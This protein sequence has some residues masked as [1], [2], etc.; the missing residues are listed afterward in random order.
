LT[1]LSDLFNTP[2]EIEFEGKA[3]KLRKPTQFEESRF[4][5]WL[6][7][8]ARADAA[9]A[10]GPDGFAERYMAVVNK[11]IAC[12]TYAWGGAAAVE[13][14]LT[15]A[16][17]TKMLQI[18]IAADDPEFTEDVAARM[19]DRKLRES[20]AKILGAAQSDPKGVRQLLT[21]LGLPPDFLSTT[22]S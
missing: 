21:F 2:S 20:A 12:L 14:L 16:G 10:T 15:P 18:I 11:N 9:R 1:P 22:S 6:E 13:A 19:A 17:M 5:T 7:D 3:Y 8:R 4:T